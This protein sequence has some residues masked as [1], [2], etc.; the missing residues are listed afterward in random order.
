MPAS[1]CASAHDSCKHVGEE[2]LGEAVAAHDTLGQGAAGVGEADAAGRGDQTLVLEAAHHLTHRRPADLEAVGD[3]R[4]DDV[5]V[6]LLQLED[7]LAVLLERRM[8]LSRYG[9]GRHCTG[10]VRGARLATAGGHTADDADRCPA[11]G[12][13]P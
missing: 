8:V 12:A 1:W 3:A 2:A 10:A 4:L 11:P 6:V 5:D 13:R 7:A 9:H